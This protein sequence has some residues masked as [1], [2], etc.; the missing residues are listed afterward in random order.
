MYADISR[1]FDPPSYVQVGADH[2]SDTV[3]MT[4]LTL[5]G[6]EVVGQNYWDWLTPNS[7]AD[8][9]SFTVTLS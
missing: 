8:Q 2:T 5:T 4:A 1:V 7:I 6:N 9:L 3:E